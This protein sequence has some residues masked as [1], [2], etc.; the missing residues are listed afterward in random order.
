MSTVILEL[1]IRDHNPAKGYHFVPETVPNSWTKA[2]ESEA[3]RV[4]NLSED[5]CNQTIR[6]RPKNSQLKGQLIIIPRIIKSGDRPAL[7]MLS[8]LWHDTLPPL[9]NISVIERKLRNE[10]F[11]D[12]GNFI[13]IRLTQN[14]IKK[15][16]IW[17]PEAVDLIGRDVSKSQDISTEGFPTQAILAAWACSPPEVRENTDLVIGGKN[18][19]KSKRRRW[20]HSFHG[21][22]TPLTSDATFLADYK[23]N[24]DFTLQ[25]LLII[26]DS[27]VGKGSWWKNFQVILDN[28]GL[29]VTMSRMALMRHRLHL[30]QTG[31]SER[32]LP[33][34]ELRSQA[35][36]DLEILLRGGEENALDVFFKAGPLLTPEEIFSMSPKRRYP[37][38]YDMVNRFEDK[39]IFITFSTL[40]YI[41]DN[42]I[43]EILKSL[44]LDFEK[45]TSQDSVGNDEVGTVT[46]L[47]EQLLKKD[48]SLFLKL[49]S[50]QE[51]KIE[52]Q[53]TINLALT[54]VNSKIPI[55][56]IPILGQYSPTLD[57]V[58]ISCDKFN[59][60]IWEDYFPGNFGQKLAEIHV[61]YIKKLPSSLWLVDFGKLLRKLTRSKKQIH[62]MIELNNWL[63]YLYKHLPMKIKSRHC[64][65]FAKFWPKSE[66]PWIRMVLTHGTRPELKEMF[67][68]E[69]TKLQKDK[70]EKLRNSLSSE[71]LGDWL[72]S[73]NS[74]L[75]RPLFYTKYSHARRE[76][77]RLHIN[78]TF[79]EKAHGIFSRVMLL[80]T[81]ISLVFL[82]FIFLKLY[83]VIDDFDGLVSVAPAAVLISWFT[84]AITLANNVL[85]RNIFKRLITEAEL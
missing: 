25:Q 47:M 41:E 54:N 74:M 48:K 23:E 7:K 20:H 76:L 43:F 33:N 82:L 68:S 31:K 57:H 8:A 15:S 32:R 69:D 26:S 77:F 24:G 84:F 18:V 72:R 27:L 13:G 10:E 55:E 66:S 28:H 30:S 53:T 81:P 9:T 17:H 14:E 85:S 83:S 62:T 1:V 61:E 52:S 35:V 40:H 22:K 80:L 56:A 65:D 44:N 12:T 50:L 59:S 75:A 4:E 21:T 73:Q 34:S 11:V 49:L 3:K 6:V 5:E 42:E 29:S 64:F 2:I 63:I 79:K 39:S 38:V 70:S 60:L 37:V 71:M 67:Y 51:S 19:A 36:S 78:P 45:I 46:L 16:T 58:L